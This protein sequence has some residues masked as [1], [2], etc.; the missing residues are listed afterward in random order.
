[1][2]KAN[3]NTKL[4]H[5]TGELNETNKNIDADLDA[6]RLG[7]SDMNINTKYNVS[8]LNRPTKM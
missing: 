2:D 5:N 8:G 6:N 3:N 1:M 7:G 4:E